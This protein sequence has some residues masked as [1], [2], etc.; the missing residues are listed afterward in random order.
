MAGLGD[1]LASTVSVT[2]LNNGVSDSLVEV[3]DW[4]DEVV[5]GLKDVNG[6]H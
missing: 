2:Y 6:E 4:L 5:D 1:R 3:V